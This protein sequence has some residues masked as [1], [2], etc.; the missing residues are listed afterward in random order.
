MSTGRLPKVAGISPALTGV[1]QNFVP[2]HSA[3]SDPTRGER[4]NNPGGALPA[5]GHD[6][7]ACWI[8]ELTTL[9]EL[10]DRLGG[11]G[12]LT[13]AL[14][15]LLRAGADLLGAR[16]G[17]FFLRPSDGLGPERLIGHGL[18][19]AELGHLETVPP[20]SAPHTRLLDPQPAAPGRPEVELTH[21]DIAHDEAL[22]PRHREVA[23]QLGCAA[24]YAVPVAVRVP[25]GPRP[26]GGQLG[27][28]VWFYDRP[29]APDARQRRLLGRYLR[30]AAQHVAN[31][32]E[33]ARARTTVRAVREELLPR[34]LPALPGVRLAVRHRHGPGR[35]GDFFDALA[36]PEG[37]L[38]L[39]IG[40][41]NGSGPATL[42]ATGSLRSGLRAYA[43]MEGEDP[44]AVLSD[45]ELLLRLTEPERTATAL[46]G[47]AEPPTQGLTPTPGPPAS[48]R[49]GTR[50]LVIASAGHPP[51]L[52]VGA[53]R[54][55]F[56]E[57]ALSAPL[58]MLACWEAPSVQL[59]I[60]QGETVLL[61]T[62]G[63]LR[64]TGE[65]LDGAFA[66][67]EAAAHR[68]PPA[69]RADP[70]AL[71]DH[72]VRTVLPSDLEPAEEV[73]LLAAR[74]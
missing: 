28:A 5:A 20:D 60:A 16:R 21:R 22:H 1:P 17:M 59:D 48:G 23:A 72:I 68:A 12:T 36:L 32:L 51:P 61:Y 31:R 45:L 18:S 24:S 27:V 37:A 63:L 58:G 42:A 65:P 30:R 13:E 7:L 39:A 29:A 34:R 47:Y 10:T 69:V 71:A 53:T 19:H 26:A 49:G 44:V 46:F 11:T 4:S 73:V 66:R 56:A 67:L 35:G 41:T 9:H 3:P 38:G 40:S 8:S 55:E 57:T 70:D 6:R 14:R 64:G 15:E 54:V 2:S 25:R 74:F 50:R 62:V 43:V 33:L 52:V